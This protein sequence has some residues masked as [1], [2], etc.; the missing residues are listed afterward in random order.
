L[1]TFGAKTTLIYVCD[2]SFC[3]RSEQLRRRA[4]R[5]RKGKSKRNQTWIATVD[6]KDIM[7]DI[8]GIGRGAGNRRK[9]G[10]GSELLRELYGFMMDVN[11]E[12]VAVFEMLTRYRDHPEEFLGE[13]IALEEILR[14]QNRL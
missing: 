5:R 9:R 6:E 12:A 14:G 1:C 10:I 13:T 4:G 8:G 2:E 11:F 7:N 3:G